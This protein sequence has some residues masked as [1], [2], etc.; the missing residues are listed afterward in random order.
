VLGTGQG[1]ECSE[2][3]NKQESHLLLLPYSEQSPF[4]VHNR[5]LGH[6][7]SLARQIIGR[8]LYG[9]VKNCS[10]CKYHHIQSLAVRSREKRVFDSCRPLGCE[11]GRAIST[12]QGHMFAKSLSAIHVSCGILGVDKVAFELVSPGQHVDLAAGRRGRLIMIWGCQ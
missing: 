7:T 3:G 12:S 6:P 10:W 9:F 11:K 8:A 5:L 4:Y 1:Y 2:E